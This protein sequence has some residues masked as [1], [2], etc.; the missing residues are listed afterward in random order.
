MQVQVYTWRVLP[1]F[2]F[3][4]SAVLD[5]EPKLVFAGAYDDASALTGALTAAAAEVPK[6]LVADFVQGATDKESPQMA[7]WRT[8]VPHLQVVFML[9]QEADEPLLVRALRSGASAYLS[10]STS[11]PV[12]KSA[13]E[14]VADGRSYLGPEIAPTALTE[15]RRNTYVVD[16]VDT[17]SMLSERQRTIVQLAADGLTNTEIA[18]E[19]GLAEKTVRN[20]WS[21]LFDQVGMQDKTQVVLWAVRTGQVELR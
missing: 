20:L 8:N 11:A 15:L 7:K 6:I 2:G 3:G 4:L 18:S 1:M 5:S 9:P 14:S 21:G 13:L 12:L 16:P 10:Y 17:A 19:L